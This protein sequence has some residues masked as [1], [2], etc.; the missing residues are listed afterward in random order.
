MHW[1]KMFPA[2]LLSGLGLWIATYFTAVSYKWVSPD[3][4]WIPQFCQ[5]K[6]KTCQ[7]V[8]HTP[9]AK[10]FGVP[11]SVFGMVLYA[12]LILF[13]LGVPLPRWIAFV[14]TGLAVVRSI[15]LAYSLIFVTKIPC[16]LCFTSHLINTTLFIYLWF[17]R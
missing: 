15:Y 8:V 5:L 14:G 12:Y 17:S 9:R 16:P 6:E 2:A 4:K 10:L 3:V 7:L 1:L 11:N 13:F